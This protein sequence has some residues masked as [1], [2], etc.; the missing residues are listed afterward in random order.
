MIRPLQIALLAA[1]I[2]L[3]GAALPDPGQI[4]S[5]PTDARCD[6][7]YAAHDF[8]KAIA[9]CEKAA[10]EY[11]S[12]SHVAATK[13]KSHINLFFEAACLYQ[14]SLSY[15]SQDDPSPTAAAHYARWS[16][17][18]VTPIL[19]EAIFKIGKKDPAKVYSVREL[20]LF[21][22]MA[23]LQANIVQTFPEIGQGV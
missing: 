13:L 7:S 11:D 16:F 12:A 2:P 14:V 9:F 23:E 5:A 21:R 4:H 1:V 18:I 6:E 10:A 22:T 17:A 15:M 8:E 3:M 19:N 20:R